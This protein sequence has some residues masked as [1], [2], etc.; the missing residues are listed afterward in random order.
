MYS[1]LF[2][3]FGDNFT[4]VGK[5]APPLP[6]IPASFTLLIISSFV[7]AVTSASAM[8]YTFFLS[9]FFS[10]TIEFTLSPTA[11]RLGSIALTVPD[12]DA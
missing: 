6:T 7:K 4:C 11:T 5:P 2:G 9:F 12:T 1:I 10:I 3:S 8:Y